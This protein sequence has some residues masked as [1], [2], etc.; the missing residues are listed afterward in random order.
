MVMTPIDYDAEEIPELLGYPGLMARWMSSEMDVTEREQGWRI[1][2]YLARNY[3]MENMSLGVANSIVHWN[4]LH[5]DIFGLDLDK[6]LIIEHPTDDG[7]NVIEDT[8]HI[9]FNQKALTSDQQLLWTNGGYSLELI[10]FIANHSKN[11]DVRRSFKIL[12]DYFRVEE[13]KIWEYAHTFGAETESVMVSPNGRLNVRSSTMQLA[14][15][16]S[17]D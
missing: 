10:W 1:L 9:K 5:T 13:H 14:E 6:V 16:L 3:L 11:N 12:L 7:G 15:L 8:M 4:S 17:G 2:K